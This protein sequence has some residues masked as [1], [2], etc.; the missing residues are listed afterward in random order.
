M[1]ILLIA[2]FP[3]SPW[4]LKNL[5]LT[6]PLSPRPSHRLAPWPSR[7]AP[8][9]PVIV[10]PIPETDTSGPVGLRCQR[11]LAWELKCLSEMETSDLGKRRLI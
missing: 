10:T 7:I 8:V 3:E 1:Y 6:V 4:A 9:A 11:L 2:E 5:G